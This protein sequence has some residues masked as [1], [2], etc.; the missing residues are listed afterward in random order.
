M[1]S[2]V[3]FPSK[4]H[5]CILLHAENYPSCILYTPLPSPPSND[6]KK[7][8]HVR[9]NTQ[10]KTVLTNSLAS[11]HLSHPFG[12]VASTTAP[13]LRAQAKAYT[14]LPARG[15]GSED[16][17]IALSLSLLL[18][19]VPATIHC[20]GALP[21]KAQARPWCLLL[22]LPS[23]SLSLTEFTLGCSLH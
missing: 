6:L 14:T 4:Q 17:S 22:L 3:H 2:C 1:I 18:I 19:Q 5:N 15:A 8:K 9:F 13:D 21:E 12:P 16:L 23:R 20:P 11:S 10:D 7:S